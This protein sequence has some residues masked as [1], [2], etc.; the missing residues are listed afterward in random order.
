[1][2]ELSIGPLLVGQPY[3]SWS[4]LNQY[5]NFS[6]HQ[7]LLLLLLNILAARFHPV[8]CTLQHDKDENV[9]FE[10]IFFSLSGGT[11]G[12]GRPQKSSGHLKESKKEF[13]V[14]VIFTC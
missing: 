11:Q 14:N 6:T 5:T 8:N 3:F 4:M 1:M 12:Y 13:S 10:E 9:R 7:E 2:A